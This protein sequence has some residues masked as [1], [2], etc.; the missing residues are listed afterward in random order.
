MCFSASAS[1]TASTVL[2]PTGIYCL[3]EARATDK[4]YIPLACWP[5]L[6]GLQQA[7]EGFVWLGLDVKTVTLIKTASLVFLFFSHF[8]WLV[9]AP[10]SAFFL[11]NNS[12]IKKLLKICV[13]LGCSYGILLYLP[14]L[15]DSYYSVKVINGSI[16]YKTKFLFEGLVSHNLSWLVYVAILLIPLGISS[17]RSLNFL[18]GLLLLSGI[19]AGLVFKY[20]FISVWCFCA[21][22]ISLYIVFVLYKMRTEAPC[23]E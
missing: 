21:A 20:A 7:V 2:I 10:L 3:K 23:S 18:G 16:Y 1:F 6:F 19:I 9:W 11:E 22:L 5:L 14:F 4:N 13:I 15:W 8:F 12:S 17:N